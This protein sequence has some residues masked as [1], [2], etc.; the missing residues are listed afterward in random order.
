MQDLH[1]KLRGRVAYT[2]KKKKQAKLEHGEE[3][4]KPQKTS[5]SVVGKR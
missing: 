4:F 2:L 3:F 5:A 1:R